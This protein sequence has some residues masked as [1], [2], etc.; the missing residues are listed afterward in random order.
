MAIVLVNG[1]VTGVVSPAKTWGELLNR[2]D[3]QRAACE[4][5]VTGVR[6]NGVDTPAFRS[7]E[8]LKMPLEATAEVYVETT[9]PADLIRNTL[10]E[11]EAV[12]ATIVEAALCLGGSYRGKDVSGANRALPEF[13]DSLGSLIVVTSAVAQSTNVDLSTL[14][15]GRISAIEMINNLIAHADTLLKAQKAR[16]W[17]QVADVI[18]YDIAG[19]VRRWPLVLKGLRQASATLVKTAA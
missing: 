4:D 2:L 17:S 16:D 7:P 12:S 18:E 5:V 11:A 14:G 19:A 1:D 9:K 13:A 15:D 3:E 8:L 10:D 6:L